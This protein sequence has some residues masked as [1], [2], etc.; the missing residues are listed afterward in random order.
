MLGLRQELTIEKGRD[1]V[2]T[3]MGFQITTLENAQ[4]I[5]GNFSFSMDRTKIQE[6]R[7]GTRNQ[8]LVVGT[9]IRDMPTLTKNEEDPIGTEILT[10]RSRTENK[11]DPIRTKISRTRSRTKIELPTKNLCSIKIHVVAEIAKSMN[12]GQISNP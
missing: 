2:N 8:D 6:P 11:E 10:I 7:L 9:K 4:N 1:T 5:G 3:E 12:I